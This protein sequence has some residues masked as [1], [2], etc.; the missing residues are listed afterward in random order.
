MHTIVAGMGLLMLACRGGY[1]LFEILQW[2][3][4]FHDLLSPE[5]AGIMAS[6]H[7]GGS[8]NVYVEIEMVFLHIPYHTPGTLIIPI[9]LQMICYDTGYNNLLIIKS[10]LIFSLKCI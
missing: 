4:S 10:T 8:E 3:I 1:G 6:V 5:Q 9:H 2:W 7:Y